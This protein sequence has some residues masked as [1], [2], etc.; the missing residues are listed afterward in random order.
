MNNK[1]FLQYICE[2]IGKDNFIR[3]VNTTDECHFKSDC[4]EFKSC[5]ECF[6][7]YL[8]MENNLKLCKDKQY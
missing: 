8:D 7:N 1:E 4:E 6:Y 3:M 5:G 2:S